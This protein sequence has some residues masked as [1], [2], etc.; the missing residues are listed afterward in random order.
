MDEISSYSSSVYSPWNV[1]QQGLKKDRLGRC[2]ERS[3]VWVRRSVLEIS[4]V[5]EPRLQI[6]PHAKPPPSTLFLHTHTQPHN[7]AELQGSP[8][9]SFSGQCHVI[10]RIHCVITKIVY[11]AHCAFRDRVCILFWIID[12]AS[13]K[14]LSAISCWNASSYV[15]Q[16]Q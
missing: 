6:L 1:G 4:V 13:L 15:I 11:N 16:I 2:K 3:A 9:V 12:N 7:G 10:A 14:V 8:T 5:V